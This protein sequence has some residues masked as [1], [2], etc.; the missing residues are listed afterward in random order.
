[1]RYWNA[2]AL[3][4]FRSQHFQANLNSAM[5]IRLLRSRAP[6]QTEP[7]P[8]Q[9]R[10]FKKLSRYEGFPGSPYYPHSSAAAPW[11]L[12]IDTMVQETKEAAQTVVHRESLPTNAD[13][14]AAVYIRC[15]VDIV[16]EANET[17]MVEYGLL[18]HR[19]VGRQLPSSISKVMIFL[20]KG[21]RKSLLCPKVIGDLERYLKGRNLTVEVKEP[22]AGT[23][24]ADWARL[25]TFRTVFSWPSTFSFTALL[26]SPHQVFFP[27]NAANMLIVE[28]PPGMFE[29][30]R[31]PHQRWYWVQTDFL[32]GRNLAAMKWEL[33]RDYLNSEFC[34]PGV[35][36]CIPAKPTC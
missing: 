2:R 19:F 8:E 32:P 36:P 34:D 20:G 10:A 27:F 24:E 25:T 16:G 9:M 14:V 33:I 30:C 4:F 18:P 1:M 21:E 5:V 3:A 6:P 31:A 26:G 22:G 17:G 29:A 23:L 15:D 7:D 28:P 11:R 12:F 35:V 13:T